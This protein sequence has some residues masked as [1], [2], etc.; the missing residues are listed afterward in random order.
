M[1]QDTVTLVQE[2][3]KKVEVIAPQAAILFYHNL[4]SIDPN[5]KVLFT[6]DM[7]KQGQKLMAMIGLAVGKLHELQEVAPV[8]QSL[9]K[10]HVKYG[11]TESHYATVG[12]ALIQTL[13]QGLGDDFTPNVKEAWTTVY[14]TMASVMIAAA[15][16]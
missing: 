3:W 13:S 12:T 1:T 4:F 14:G 11:V 5:L 6:G 2:S 8:L 16:A 7:E 10:R 15:Q 9:A